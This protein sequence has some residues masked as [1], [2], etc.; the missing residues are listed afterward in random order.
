MV[1]SHHHGVRHPK[2]HIAEPEKKEEPEK[3]D[4]W[5]VSFKPDNWEFGNTKAIPDFDKAT[6]S[7]KE[8]K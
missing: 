2:A 6:D 1:H 8:K 4:F 7:F 3:D 5:D